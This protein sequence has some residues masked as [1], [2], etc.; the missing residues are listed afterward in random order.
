MAV[1]R[2][3]YSGKPCHNAWTTALKTENG[4]MSVKHF[5]GGILAHGLKHGNMRRA[6]GVF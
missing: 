5:V 1:F 2:S 4:N 6:K 3:I